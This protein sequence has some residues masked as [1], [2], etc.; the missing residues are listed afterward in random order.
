MHKDL[1]LAV[2]LGAQ[3]GIPLPVASAVLARVDEAVAAGY[4][5]D[6]FLSLVRVQQAASGR[7]VDGAP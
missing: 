2:S 5:D 7:P 6:D 4:A 1:D 3:S